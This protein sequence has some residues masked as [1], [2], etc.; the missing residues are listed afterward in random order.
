MKTTKQPLLLGAHISVSG[1][2]D[3]AISR[4][5]S[6][7]CTA[8][9]IFTKSNRQWK[10]APISNEQAELFIQT[11]NAST[12]KVVVAHA[13][14]LINIGSS[15]PEVRQKSVAALIDELE[16]CAQLTIPFLVLHPGSRGT[17]SAEEFLAVFKEQL[18]FVL[19]Q[20]KSNTTILL[21]TMAGQGSVMGHT[22]EQIGYMLRSSN[23]PD[24]LGVCADTC[25]M[26]AAGYNLSTDEYE[27]TWQLFDAHIG[28]DKLKALHIN[29]SKKELGSKVDRH[30]D[31][32]KGKI[33]IDAF[34]LLFN[35]PRFFTTPKLLETPKESLEDDL[36]NM[37]TL[38]GLIK[39]ENKNIL[40][41]E[42]IFTRL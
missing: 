13:A 40:D 3:Q 42:Q 30:E 34:G 1:G 37:Q 20:A 7:G 33:G 39:R 6:I 29:D 23:Y 4:A 21:E 25:H 41:T 14:Y 17:F 15:N 28:L 8:M 5:E 27:K 32:G 26:F 36:R 19:S 31:I 38:I 35:D 12:I 10:S 11:Q 9:Q 18:D 24:R 22:F 2:F 16:R